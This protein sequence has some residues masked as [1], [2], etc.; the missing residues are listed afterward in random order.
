MYIVGNPTDDTAAFVHCTQRVIVDFAEEISSSVNEIKDYEGR[1]MKVR[2]C[3]LPV[4]TSP[5]SKDPWRISVLLGLHQLLVS[6]DM[7][8]TDQRTSLLCHSIAFTFTCK[9][10]NWT[11]LRRK[12]NTNEI[13]LWKRSETSFEFCKTCNKL[14]P[15][16]SRHFSSKDS[17][18]PTEGC[19]RREE[20]WKL[21]STRHIYSGSKN[22]PYSSHF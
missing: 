21:S 13:S 22:Y 5:A 1:I 4:K 17:T 6:A 16:H 20:H 19:R 2:T 8:I 11:L 3:I 14:E 7:T 12:K 9:G 15:S 18:E 10:N